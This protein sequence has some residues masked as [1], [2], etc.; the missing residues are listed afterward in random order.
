MINL[1]NRGE[2]S[3]ARLKTLILWERGE[4]GDLEVDVNVLKCQINKLNCN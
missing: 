1:I 4:N 3:N 2:N